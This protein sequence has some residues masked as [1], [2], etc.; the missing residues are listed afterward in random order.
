MNGLSISS[1]NHTCALAQ[2]WSQG[3][4]TSPGPRANLDVEG[5]RLSVE[6]PPLQVGAVVY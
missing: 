6:L 3:D 4:R 5:C 1:S 2:V